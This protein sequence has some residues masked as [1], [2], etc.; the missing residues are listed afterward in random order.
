MISSMLSFTYKNY[1]IL[2]KVVINPEL[3]YFVPHIWIYIFQIRLELCNQHLCNFDL[4]EYYE[5]LLRNRD[6]EEN[7]VVIFI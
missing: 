5:L 4:K 6:T 7:L 3:T 2:F 1:L